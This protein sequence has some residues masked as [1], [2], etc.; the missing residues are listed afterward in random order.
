MGT[1]V[2]RLERKNIAEQVFFLTWLHIHKLAPVKILAVLQRVLTHYLTFYIMYSAAITKSLIIKPQLIA[3]LI[4][5]LALNG[6]PGT[7]DVDDHAGVSHCFLIDKRDQGWFHYI[8]PEIAAGLLFFQ[9]TE[10]GDLQVCIHG[11]RNRSLNQE[12]L[13]VVFFS[14][15]VELNGS[16]RI[17][18]HTEIGLVVVLHTYFLVNAVIICDLPKKEKLVIIGKNITPAIHDF[19]DYRVIAD[20]G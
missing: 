11:Q 10:K 12:K 5:R 14:G 15:G 20:Q 6:D 1:P 13:L 18:A 4:N 16:V 8:L 2:G 9:N 17:K 3:H 19:A 7:A